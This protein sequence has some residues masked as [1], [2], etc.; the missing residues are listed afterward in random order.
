MEIKKENKLE[1]IIMFEQNNLKYAAYKMVYSGTKQ[2]FFMV[3]DEDVVSNCV[4]YDADV[5]LNQLANSSEKFPND[6]IEKIK[7]KISDTVE[8]K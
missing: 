3:R 7:T 6:I 2:L 1:T 8:T 4:S 5:F